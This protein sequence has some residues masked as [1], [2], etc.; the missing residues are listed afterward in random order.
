MRVLQIFHGLG[1][2]GAETW[3]LSLLRYWHRQAAGGGLEVKTDIL[4]TG[5]E[6]S[7]YDDEAAS[8]GARLHY[9]RSTR[10]EFPR[11]ARE[12]R[13]I[14]RHGFYQAVHSHADYLAGWHFGL[15]LGLLPRVRVA[16]VHNPRMHIDVNYSISPTRRL[17]T[18]L[19]SR[20]INHFATH[21]CGTSTTIL[22][23]YGFGPHS[24][25]RP[26]VSTLHCGIEVERF[27]GRRQ[28]DHS[29]V[30]TEFR[31]PPTSQ[32]I[33]FAGRLDRVMAFD[34][35][36]N[37][38]NS[39]FALHAAREA[40]MKDERVRFIMAGAGDA[41]RQ[42][43]EDVVSDWGLSEQIKLVGVR[44]DIPRLMRGSNC[45]LFPSRQEGLGMVA[46]EAQAAGLPV[47]ASTA[48]PKE[49]VVVPTLCDFLELDAG[50]N[51]WAQVMLAILKRELP[52]A[53]HC[54][55]MVINSPFSI[56]H[57]ASQLSSIYQATV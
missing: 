46:V 48:V 15:G 36:T 23:E 37:H 3:L 44:H 10:K 55:Q 27:T 11:F 33:L 1:T 47:L 56:E 5:G 43:L 34:D 19:G 2:G 14:Y 17:T 21:V 51:V 8:L 57:S 53:A 31:W 20:L 32:I 18:W 30:C 42:Q 50:P 40:I 41:M 45:L 25:G 22:R 13:A 39:W 49:C 4:L 12:L 52:Q 54:A 6:R 16:H 9:I 26:R 28:Q 29:A 35:P 24:A 38:K 7:T